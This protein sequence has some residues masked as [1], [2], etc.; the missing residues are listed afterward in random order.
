MVDNPAGAFVSIR[1]HAADT[2]GNTVYQT[3]IHAYRVASTA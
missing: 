2:A 1:T 3:V